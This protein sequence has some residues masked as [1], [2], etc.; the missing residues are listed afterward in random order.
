MLCRFCNAVSHFCTCKGSEITAY[1]AS[2]VCSNH[3]VISTDNLGKARN[4]GAFDRGQI[5]DV[6]SMGH[7]ISRNHQRTRI[8]PLDSSRAY[9]EYTDGWEKT[10]NR[11]NYKGL[12]ALNDGGS[13]L[14]S[15]I[16]RSQRSQALTQITT[17]LNQ[18]TSCTGSTRWGG[19]PKG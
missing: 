16:V 14:L 6:R 8:F 11:A 19:L 10:S 13:R 4:L 2:S 7:S 17:Q 3:S 18:G 12:L 5:I 9:P 15:R 1:K